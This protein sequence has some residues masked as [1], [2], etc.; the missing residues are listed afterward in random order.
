MNAASP[1]LDSEGLWDFRAQ[2]GDTWHL[3]Q[4]LLGHADVFTTID[5]QSEPFRDRDFS[6]LRSFFWFP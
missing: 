3:V 6:C 4:T 2:F 1:H 5:T